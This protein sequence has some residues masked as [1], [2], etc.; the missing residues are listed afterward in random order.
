MVDAQKINKLLEGI[1]QVFKLVD[2]TIPEL[3]FSVSDVLCHYAVQ[4]GVPQDEFLKILA[5]NYK[6]IEQLKK[7]EAVKINEPNK[8]QEVIVT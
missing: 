5:K 3:L 2:P 6:E 4:A 8:I 7:D 1:E